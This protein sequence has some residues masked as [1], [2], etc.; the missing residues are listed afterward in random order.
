MG[1]SAFFSVPKHISK[2]LN[3]SA[4]ILAAAAVVAGCGGGGGG[5]G[6][7][8][9][10]SNTGGTPTSGG[11]VSTG[12]NPATG[13]QVW[14]TSGTVSDKSNAQPIENAFIDVP[15]NTSNFNTSSATDGTYTLAFPKSVPLPRFFTGNVNKTGYLPGTIFYNFENNQLIALNGSQNVQL[16]PKTEQDVVFGKTLSVVHL[17]D[18][19][20]EGAANS[21]LQVPSSGAE[22]KDSVSFT[23]TDAQRAQF[24]KLS[25]TMLARGVQSASK[26]YCDQLVV[27]SLA[28]GQPIPGGPAPQTLPETAADGSFTQIAPLEF[29]LSQ[30]TAGPIELL[31]SSGPIGNCGGTGEIDDFE[32]V[33]VVGHLSQ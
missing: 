11:G 8:G 22:L 24:T 5:G 32:F 1:V 20:F 3:K 23:L 30:L 17:G 2:V 19:T 13:T 15:L 29:S 26:S 25:I 6:D 9:S 10:T 16:T 7:G 21:Q 33:S 31:I 28:N 14:V 27:R 4:L 12:T 18:G